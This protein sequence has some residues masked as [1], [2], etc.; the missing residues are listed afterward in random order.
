MFGENGPILLQCQELVLEHPGE[1]SESIIQVRK[2][3]ARWNHTLILDRTYENWQDK[4]ADIKFRIK[5]KDRKLAK[6]HLNLEQLRKDLDD[7]EGLTAKSA[8]IVGIGGMLI[9]MDFVIDYSEVDD[10]GVLTEENID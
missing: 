2:G 7:A 3:I 1:P 9:T 6:I 10:L 4:E 5:W 8:H